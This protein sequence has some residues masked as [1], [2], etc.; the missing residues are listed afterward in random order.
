MMQDIKKIRNQV[1]VMPIEALNKNDVAL[2]GLLSDANSSYKKGAAAAPG[3]IRR[4]LHC[5]SSNLCSESGID[6]AENPRFVDLGD[7]PVTD[8]VESFLAI[9]NEIC[10]LTE[11]GA[12]PLVLGGDHAVSYPV[13]RAI[14]ARHGPVNILHFDAHPDLYHD[15]EGNPYSHASPFARIMEQS[16]ATRLVQVGIRTLNQGQREQVKRFGVET[17]EMATLDIDSVGRDFVGP[18]YIS[19]DIDALDPAF[20]PGVSHHEPGGLS[21]R[22]ILTIIQ[23]LP[24]RIVGADIVEYNPSR[25][26]ND[27]TAMVA[28]KLLKEIAGQMLLNSPVE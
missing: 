5:G 2:I 14:H 26:I 21:V 23:R 10:T 1:Q 18:V 27:M 6:L 4:A 13:L 7:R 9:E 22:D 12:L 3:H 11:P 28:A 20:A 19:C 24:N 16:L 8:D 15:Y 25:D 17:H